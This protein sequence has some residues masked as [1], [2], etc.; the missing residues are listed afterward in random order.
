MTHGAV[1]PRGRIAILH[2]GACGLEAVVA[3]GTALRSSDGAACDECGRGVFRLAGAM[4]WREMVE[5]D[6]A[7]A[8]APESARTDGAKREKGP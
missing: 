2:C 5:R 8:R 3:S 7:R 1:P 4:T 6:V